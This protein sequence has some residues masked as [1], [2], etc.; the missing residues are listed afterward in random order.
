VIGALSI[1]S[2]GIAR[3]LARFERAAQGIASAN[4]TST[5]S[6]LVGSAVDLASAKTEVRANTA[7]LRASDRLLGTLLDVLA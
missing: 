4:A 3:G 5:S 1:A 7:V 6:D 2:D